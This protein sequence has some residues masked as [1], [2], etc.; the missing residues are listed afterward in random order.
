MS[1][2]RGRSAWRWCAWAL[3]AAL[4]FASLATA[5]GDVDWAA[6]SWTQP[7]GLPL[8]A[9]G[10]A[11]NLVV[12]GLLYWVVTRSF[13]TAVSVGAG[14]MTALIAASHL[15]NYLPLR[16]G[17]LGRAAYLK[18]RHGLAL[19][20]SVRVTLTVTTLGVAV[21]LAA[22]LCPRAAWAWA[23]VVVAGTFATP[24]LARTALRRPI[25]AGWSW[26]PLRMLDLLASSLRLWAGSQVVGRPLDVEIAVIA[27]AAGAVVSMVGLTPNGLGM[28]EW[29]LALVAE[30]L[31]PGAMS[32]AQ[33]AAAIDRAVELLVVAPVGSV[34]LAVL[35]TNP[36][37]ATP[38]P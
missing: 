33:L 12:T 24:L 28:R 9:V 35:G 25:L 37:Q 19:W 26:F 32:V 30:S 22:V 11:A 13:P 38:N 7:R 10:V 17:L 18:L 1:Q 34:S 27:S 36:S 14:T 20:D 15:L 16:P 21:A 8:I 23:G 4:F 31:S 5:L 2:A 3:G 29:A 6:L